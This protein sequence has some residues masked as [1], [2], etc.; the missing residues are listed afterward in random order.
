MPRQSFGGKSSTRQ[1]VEGTIHERAVLWEV[2][3]EGTIHE[4]AVL[5][6]VI[7]QVV[8]YWEQFSKGLSAR[9]QFVGENFT[10]GN[11]LCTA[12]EN[13]LTNYALQYS[14]NV[15]DLISKC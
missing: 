5:W 11:S 12:K 1:F 10:E 4:R 13:Q 14:E 9:R 3:F 2:I 15:I 7:F 8:I 6:E